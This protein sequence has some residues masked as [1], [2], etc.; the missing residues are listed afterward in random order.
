MTFN[1]FF[2]DDTGRHGLKEGADALWLYK[3]CELCLL[4]DLKGNRE[5]LEREACYMH[6]FLPQVFCPGSPR[7]PTPAR[8][9]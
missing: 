4:D 7:R 2:K 3:G 8:H 1:D 9:F 6:Y 5:A